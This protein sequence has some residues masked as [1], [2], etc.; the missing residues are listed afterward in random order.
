MYALIPL[1][2]I[3]IMAIVAIIYVKRTETRTPAHS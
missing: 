3:L 2:G 1:T